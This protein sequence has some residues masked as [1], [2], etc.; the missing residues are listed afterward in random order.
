MLNIKIFI[1]AYMLSILWDPRE[2]KIIKHL[3]YHLV[4]AHI[5]LRMRVTGV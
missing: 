5:P 4:G 2:R 3:G 1:Y